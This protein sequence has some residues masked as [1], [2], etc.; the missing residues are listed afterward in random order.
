MDKA[1]PAEPSA[2][3]EL[4][5]QIA[6][7]NTLKHAIADSYVRMASHGDMTSHYIAEQQTKCRTWLLELKDIFE[8]HPD[9]LGHLN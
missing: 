5:F 6:R 1:H 2:E 3:S 4:R 8:E 9:V 7:V